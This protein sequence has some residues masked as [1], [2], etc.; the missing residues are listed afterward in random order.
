M[1]M[2]R[3][4]ADRIAGVEAATPGYKVI[5]GPYNVDSVTV[6]KRN[7]DYAREAVRSQE[8]AGIPWKVV[9]YRGMVYVLRTADGW[10]EKEDRNMTLPKSAKGLVCP[11]C[12]KHP[13]KS[14]Q[15]LK[16]HRCPRLPIVHNWG[17]GNYHG[18]LTAEHIKEALREARRV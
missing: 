3:D 4:S 5:G 12:G 10:I 13:F 14:V 16:I 11:L 6:G 9:K 2:K 18:R 1:N 8:R 17:S 15:G 7:E